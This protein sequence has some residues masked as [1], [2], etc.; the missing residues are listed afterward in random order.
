MSLFRSRISHCTDLLQLGLFHVLPLSFVTL[1]SWIS[2]APGSGGTSLLMGR[3]CVGRG[4]RCLEEGP[5]Y[6]AWASHCVRAGPL[7]PACLPAG[8]VDRD[9][10]VQGPPARSLHHRVAAS[11]F[12]CSMPESSSLSAAPTRGGAPSAIPW[13]E[14]LRDAVGMC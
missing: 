1:A 10:V 4:S 2:T 9:R 6:L 5:W 3:P 8:G 13:R 7:V 11:P 12:P 14:D